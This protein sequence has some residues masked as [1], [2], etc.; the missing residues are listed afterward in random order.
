MTALC[1]KQHSALRQRLLLFDHLVGDRE[2]LANFAPA[3]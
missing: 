1:Q 2:Q 3:V